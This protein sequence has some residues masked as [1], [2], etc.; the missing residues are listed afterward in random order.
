MKY[1]QTESELLVTTNRGNEIY[2]CCC[3]PE[4]SP[5]NVIEE[6]TDCM[7]HLGLFNGIHDHKN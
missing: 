4:E 2:I 1:I 3:Y 5:P 6:I 7:A